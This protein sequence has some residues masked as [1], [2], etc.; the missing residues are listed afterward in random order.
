M[1]RKVVLDEEC[2]VGCGSCAELCPE[3]FEMDEQIQKAHV[4]KPEGGSEAS[5]P[6]ECIAWE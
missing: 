6:E 3:I 4:T 5:C 2:R 1:G